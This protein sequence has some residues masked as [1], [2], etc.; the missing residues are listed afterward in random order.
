M[1]HWTPRTCCSNNRNWNSG[2]GIVTWSLEQHIGGLLRGW[3]VCWEDLRRTL[4]GYHAVLA[5]RGSITKELYN[6]N[7]HTYSPIDTISN[8]SFSPLPAPLHPTGR[9]PDTPAPE[10]L[11]HSTA[12]DNQSKTKYKPWP[13]CKLDLQAENHK[14]KN[15]TIAQIEHEGETIDALLY[16]DNNIIVIIIIIIIMMVFVMIIIIVIIAIIW[17]Q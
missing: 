3:R 7:W 6:R 11:K 15:K 16:H 8:I 13:N 4:V 2:W 9:P 1:V 10:T 17:W 12:V 14:H 5:Q